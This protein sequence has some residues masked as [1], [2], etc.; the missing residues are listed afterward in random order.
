M[1][2][3]QLGYCGLKDKRAV[4]RQWFSVHLP[5]GNA[6][7]WRRLN[8]GQLQVLDLTRHQRKLRVGVHNGN[9]FEI[10]LRAVDA[11]PEQL[12]QRCE[13]LAQHGFP[14]YFGPQRFGHGNANLDAARRLFAQQPNAWKKPSRKQRLYISAA[15]AHVFNALA[16]SRVADGSWTQPLE[17]DVFQFDG[18]GSLFRDRLSEDTADRLENC[19]LHITGPLW[20]AGDLLS[21][22]AV[23]AQERHI[24][25]TNADL[26]VGLAE[27]GMGQQRRALRARV[28]Q[29]HWELQG[30]DLLLR[31]EL[32]KGSYATSLLRE[33]VATNVR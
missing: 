20:G 12:R 30:H 21:S 7:D 32:V 27:L 1:K 8:D 6:P 3:R 25:E 17:G 9:S 23:A 16:S 33:L 14:N 22:G 2:P 19:Y 18:G 24:A 4:T 15:R 13:L 29:L 5:T 26:A 11:D 10:R 31:F 28:K